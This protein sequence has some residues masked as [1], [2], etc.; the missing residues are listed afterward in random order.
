MNSPIL[1]YTPYLWPLWV[2][3]GLL[4][5]LGL[6]AWRYRETA[7]LPFALLTLLAAATNLLYSL[8]AAAA[9]LP[10]KVLASEW[11]FAPCA[12]LPPMVLATARSYTGSGRGFSPLGWAALLCVPTLTALA[13]LVPAFHALF[14]DGFHLEWRG[15]QPVLLWENGPWF[16]VHYLYGSLLVW[17]SCALLL[18][19]L[20]S[21]RLKRGDTLLFLLGIALPDA[22]DILFQ[23]RLLPVRGFNFAFPAT[24]FTGLCF[25]WALLRGRAFEA[26]PLARR[27]VLDNLGDPLLILDPGLRL[28]DGNRAARAH[29][30]IGA[31]DLGRPAGEC[32]PAA[33]TDLLDG[34]DG[35]EPRRKEAAIE[36][37]RHPERRRVYRLALS[38]ILEPGGGL[39]GHLLYGHEITAHKAAETALRDSEQRF[40]QLADNTTDVFW[41]A[42]WPEVKL[43]YISPAFESIWGVPR[44]ALYRDPRRRWRASVHPGDRPW[45]WRRWREQVERGQSELE[46]RIVRPDG[47]VRWIEDRSRLIADGRG[48][49]IVGIAR[50][51]T[52]AK[53]LSEE[54]E[55]HRHHLEDLVAERT[56]QLEEARR[57]AESANAAK[58]SFLANMSHEIRTPI[59][60]V[61][62]LADLCLQTGLSERQ[63]GYLLKIKGAST[64]LLGIIN[65]ILDFSKIEAGKL[66]LEEIEFGLDEVLERLAAV[67]AE[68]ARERGLEL[69]FDGVERVSPRLV[70]DPLRLGQVLI[71]LVG[72][73]VKF[74]AR[75]TVAVDFREEAGDGGVSIL[76]VA[77]SDQGIGLTPAQL[78][79]LFSPFSQA[80]CSTTRRYGGTGLGLAISRRLVEMMGGTLS[81][82]SEY[83][84]GSVFRFGVRLRTGRGG[85]LPPAGA[86]IDADALAAPL[87]GADILLVED[88]IINREVLVELLDGRGL[89]VRSAE[90][91]LQALRAVAARKPDAVLMDCQM[92]VMDGYEACR[93][94]RANPAYRDL[95]IIALT[96]NAL[97]SDRERCLAAG[98][99]AYLVKPVDL[100]ALLRA[101][102]QWVGPART[103]PE[104]APP[105]APATA[106]DSV[107]AIDMEAGL[108]RVDH[109]RELY[110]R[111]L[112]KFRNEHLPGFE[113]AFRAAAA[114]GNW[115]TA[116]RSAHSLKGTARTLGA[117]RLGD[118]AAELEVLARQ[119]GPVEEALAGLAVELDRVAAAIDALPE[120]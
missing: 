1:V 45:L 67:V 23:L 110:L 8:E 36:P 5:A 18:A 56:A 91:G 59:S 103:G 58:G 32:L 68:K 93:A 63:R 81:A 20:R 49:R 28:A 4:G 117:E 33:W 42:E 107:P 2:A 27:I 43:L 71:N 80:D 10:L 19:A 15:V 55:R 60:A 88:N 112:R 108:P 17:T 74:S 85:V 16:M 39:L 113:A 25:G 21:P 72:N 29:W 66:E 87:R 7:A 26:M 51:I 109:N 104:A 70:G 44:Q 3:A 102:V 24:L 41:V 94:L 119:A 11:R 115:E 89:R 62:G 38:P 54:L 98:M 97:D 90:N 75:G 48:F 22:V 78:D 52:R 57:Q 101:L 114:A 106:A 6:Y 100:E 61:L 34:Y 31:A 84:R 53:Q 79:G 76:H 92:P 82:E 9:A 47:G 69:V 73:A 120:E 111:L 50:D 95:P 99:N 65:D 30:T 96:A 118:R 105:A 40:R 83:G 12:F 116:R 86:A 46:Y 35:R 37:D 64:G 13:P 14:R 77:V